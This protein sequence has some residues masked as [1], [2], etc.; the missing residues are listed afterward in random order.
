MFDVSITI[1]TE[2]IEGEVAAKI[3][4][5]LKSIKAEPKELWFKLK[6]ISFAT[7][8]TQLLM[9]IIKLVKN[10]NLHGYDVKLAIIGG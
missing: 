4:E 1:T 10:I 6:R 3:E 7:G 8:D 2:F 9:D 5:W